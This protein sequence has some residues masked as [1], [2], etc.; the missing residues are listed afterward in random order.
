[1]QRGGG[2]ADVA[3]DVDVVDQDGHLEAAIPR[4]G[5]D[6]GD[7][8]LVPVDE[9]DALAD[10]LRIPA[11]GLVIGRGDHVLDAVG[12]DADT[13]LYRALGPGCAWRRAGGAAM[14]SGSRTRG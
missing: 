2:L 4:V 9:E 14:S 11:V 7:L 8:L 3:G 5:L 10:P 12:D 1:M 13:H 6:G